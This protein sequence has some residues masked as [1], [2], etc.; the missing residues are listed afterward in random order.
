M[1]KT[2]EIGKSAGKVPKS[3]WFGYGTP[4]TTEIYT[5]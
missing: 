1:V 3:I 5:L 2:F 4:S